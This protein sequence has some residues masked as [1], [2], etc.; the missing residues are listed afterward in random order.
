[1]E[2]GLFLQCLVT[3]M[4]SNNISHFLYDVWCMVLFNMKH[5]N[6]YC[7]FIFHGNSFFASIHEAFAYL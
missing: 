3:L 4:S 6:W 5:E 2:G 1:M 7:V